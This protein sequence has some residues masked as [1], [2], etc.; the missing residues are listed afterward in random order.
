M[1]ASGRPASLF[2]KALWNL[3]MLSFSRMQ[4]ALSGRHVPFNVDIVPVVPPQPAVLT[5]VEAHPMPSTGLALPDPVYK[6]IVESRS[7]ALRAWRNYCGLS[8]QALHNRTRMNTTTLAAFD[9]GD[10]MLCEWT[11]G[12]LAKALH[13]KPWQLLKAQAIASEQH[14]CSESRDKGL[15]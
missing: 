4:S 11:V 6:A 5:T 14:E 13:V 10:V 3:I 12:A 1:R 9:H 15:R 8:M 7:S 2:N